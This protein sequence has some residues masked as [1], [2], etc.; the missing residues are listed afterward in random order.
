MSFRFE[1]LEVWK[2]AREY[3]GDIY[4]VTKNFP[5][6]EI[7]GLTSQLKRA[8]ISIVNNIAEG[9]DRKSDTE[10]GI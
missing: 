7:F 4:R 10:L 5:K 2:M 3:V 1:N 6:E 9:S 8:A